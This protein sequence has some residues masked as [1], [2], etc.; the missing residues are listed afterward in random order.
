MIKQLLF[1]AAIGLL[2]TQSF[3]QTGIGTITPA[4]NAALDITSTSKG[5]LIPRMTS[6]QRS[7]N[8][9]SPSEGMMVY[10]TDSVSG[11]YLYNSAQWKRMSTAPDVKQYFFQSTGPASLTSASPG[12]SYIPGLYQTITIDA[13]STIII[14]GDV[15]AITTGT[16]GVGK[17]SKL[18]NDFY[19]NGVAL[20]QY[21][22]PGSYDLLTVSDPGAGA[23]VNNGIGRIHM[24]TSF[25]ID[26]GTY[27]FSIIPE[28]IYSSNDGVDVGT[29][30][31][32][33]TMSIQVIKK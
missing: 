13:P 32:P 25:S 18:Y 4:A 6:S 21:G 1:A 8:I 26:P 31:D 12:P 9:V 10:Q 14:N 24:N 27:E 3:A 19:I 15:S 33:S 28:L 16:P 17:Y 11:I 20:F 2:T 23:T 5:L 29:I 30:F 22:I 7:T